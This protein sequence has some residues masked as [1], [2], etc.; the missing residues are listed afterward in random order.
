MILFPFHAKAVPAYPGA[1][2]FRQSD[3][4][5]LTYYLIGDEHCHATVTADGLVV[6]DNGNGALCYAQQDENGTVTTT[7][8]IAHNAAERNSTEIS[9]VGKLGKIDFSRQYRASQSLRM[10]SR[11]TGTN[12]FPTIGAVRGLVLLV[13]FSD[14]AF[15]PAYT[16]DVFN[17]QM[18]DSAYSLNG[19]TGSSRNYFIDQSKGLFTPVFDV[20]GPIKLSREMAY[21]GGNSIT[22]TDEHAVDMIVDACR[23]A[24]DSL[25]VDFSKYDYNNDGE[26]DFV[27]AIYAGYGENYGASSNT[28][29]PHTYNVMKAGQDVTLDGK[30]LGRYACSCE[31]RNNTGATIDGI[32]VFCHE[33]SHVL[34][35]PD[36]YNTT[37][38]NASQWGSWS[39][40]DNGCYNNSA[41]TP[42]GYS[43]FERS[44]LGW[45]NTTDIDTPQKEMSLEELSSSLKAYRLSTSNA[46]EYYILENRQQTGWDKYLPGTGLLISHIDYDKT[47]WDANK[48]N[49]TD[50]HPRVDIMEADGTQT[51]ESDAGDS[52]PGTTGKTEFTDKTTPSSLTWDGSL[53]DKPITNIKETNG[54]IT[55]DF[56]WE[57]LATP[58]FTDS[59]GITPSS[60]TVGW[61][62]VKRATSYIFHA[63]QVLPD[64][65]QK[66]VVN[67]NF[68]KLLSG[69]Y[70][71]SARIDMSRH[72]DNFTSETGWTGYK[73]YQAGGRI[74]VGREDKISGYLTT[75]AKD[76]SKEN[77][78]FTVAFRAKALPD[79]IVTFRVSATADDT[80]SLGSFLVTVDS[81]ETAV[82]KTFNKGS[83]KTTVTIS[84]DS[85]CVFVDDFQLARG[86]YSSSEIWTVSP[87]SWTAADLSACNY[88]LSGLQAGST[89]RYDIQAIYSNSALNSLVSDTKTV[90]LPNTETKVYSIDNSSRIVKT[91]KYYDTAGRRLSVPARGINIVVTTYD[92]GSRQSVVIC[93]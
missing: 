36:L 35:L 41:R 74:K 88:T 63:E 84:T 12:P 25:Q 53:L 62:P 28:I 21:Y 40:L 46:N 11:V 85:T 44:S 71:T 14:N 77:G 52:Y 55:F 9:F 34:G 66:L 73:L 29:W 48:V 78:S 16:H 43:A 5:V 26:V 38:S 22:I 23:K 69:S 2:S 83:Q 27:Y 24:H 76:L 13:E 59:V 3:G 54:I 50:G 30:Q 82:V 10:P 93:K 42:A 32:G 49:N 8:Q 18:N 60:F 1:H 65:L 7:A 75:P 90:T 56:E 20:V 68:N 45:M 91:V 86:I 72:L 61:N 57:A 15:N 39:I 37:N 51:L 87:P 17:S 92:D 67:E 19:A 33:F 6:R 58:T 70:P 47:V 79:S 64:S 80:L 89:Y 31:L 81:T 4:T